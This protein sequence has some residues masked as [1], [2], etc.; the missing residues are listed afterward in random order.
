M[1]KMKLA[2]LALAL[3]GVF[4]AGNAMAAT[5]D[6]T[7]DA[8]VS[9]AC[10]A[11]TTT[12]I[13]IGA[14][15]PTVE[16]TTISSATHGGSTQGQI[17]V[18]CTAGTDVTFSAPATVTLNGGAGGTDTMVIVP[19]V[20]GTTETPGIAGSDYDVNA[21]VTYAEYSTASAGAYSGSFTVT[22][23]P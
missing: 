16:T 7:V 8:T 6:V 22:V 19:I 20:P 1:K 11:T 21:S 5:T 2:V 12:D 23:T 3:V 4:A 18:M 10:I 15:D 17:K 9:E 13:V 14:I